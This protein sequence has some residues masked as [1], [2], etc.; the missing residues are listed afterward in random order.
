MGSLCC[1]AIR[2]RLG[3]EAANS[4]MRAIKPALPISVSFKS[5]CATILKTHKFRLDL[6]IYKKYLKFSIFAMSKLVELKRQYEERWHY[7]PAMP[8][9]KVKEISC[10]D[11]PIYGHRES[12]VYR[13]CWAHP[14]AMPL[15]S[16]LG[17][18]WEFPPAG[19]QRR[20]QPPPCRGSTIPAHL[21][22]LTFEQCKNPYTRCDYQ[23]E[24]CVHKQILV[25]EQKIK[26]LKRVLAKAKPLQI[27]KVK[28]MRYHGVRYRLLVGSTGCTKIYPEYLSRMAEE[29]AL[30]EFQR[31]YNDVNQSK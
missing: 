13:A 5:H 12:P 2:S 3:C 9:E 31:A 10:G 19:Q 15:Q 8:T 6:S 20:P 16:R 7:P 21:L 14:I 26:T 30:C 23:L 4:L 24:Q 1:L 28:Q 11:V 18:C 17:V 22:E 25:L 27:K 29:R